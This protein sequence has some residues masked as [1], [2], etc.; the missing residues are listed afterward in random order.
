MNVQRQLIIAVVDAAYAHVSLFFTGLNNLCLILVTV[1]IKQP[2]R[3]ANGHAQY[4]EQMDAGLFFQT[5]GGVDGKG[6]RGVNAWG[7]H[8]VSKLECRSLHHTKA[9]CGQSG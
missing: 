6:F 5:D 8:G 4:P 1:A 9:G 2:N 3:V 7:G